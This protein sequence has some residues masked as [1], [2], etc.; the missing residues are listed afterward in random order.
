MNPDPRQD[1]LVTLN[2]REKISLVMT[3]R[4]EVS[5]NSRIY[6]FALP[7]PKHALGLPCGKHLFVYANIG[8]ET[9]MR[10]YT[11]ISSDEDLGRLDLLIKVIVGIGF[12]CA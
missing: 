9:V 4:I 7:S 8:G 1:E 6:R 2:P 10:A 12:G 11:P 3:E 5:P